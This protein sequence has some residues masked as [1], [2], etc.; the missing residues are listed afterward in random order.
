[1]STGPL[2]GSGIVE[3]EDHLLMTIEDGADRRDDLFL[4]H[5]HE[6]L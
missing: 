2:V 5:F 1:M 6:V 3:L 4:E